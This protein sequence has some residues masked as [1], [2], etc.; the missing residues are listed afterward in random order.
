MSK[1]NLVATFVAA[2]LCLFAASWDTVSAQRAKDQNARGRQLY[3]QYCASCHG[4]DARGGGPV[5]VSLKGTVPDLHKIAK[6]DGKFP[7]LRVKQIIKGEV[8]T[9]AHGT[10]EMP[11]WGRVFREAKGNSMTELNLYALTKYL[12]AI[13]EK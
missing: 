8:D 10:K 2:A 4:D 7:A 11:V 1:R 6:V 5:A 9:P 13:Q 3:Y 12:E